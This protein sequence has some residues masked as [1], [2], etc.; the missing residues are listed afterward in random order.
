[1]TNGFSSLVSWWSS[2]YGNHSSVAV[3]V[4]VLH[5]AGIVVGGGTALTVDRQ[6]LRSRHRGQDE[7]AHALR[8]LGDAHSVVVAAMVIIG[9]TGVLMFMADIDTFVHSRVFWTKM[10]FVLFLAANGGLLVFARRP[11][12]VARGAVSWRSLT[13]SAAISLSLWLLLI[14]LGEWLRVSG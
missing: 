8:L 10:A 12:D 6:V 3:T 13:L 7:R 4:T 2:L 5:L 11:E 9:L 14:L 1:M